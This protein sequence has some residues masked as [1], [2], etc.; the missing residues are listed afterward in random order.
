MDSTNSNIAFL[1]IVHAKDYIAID[2]IKKKNKFTYPKI[3]DYKNK[4]GKLNTIPKDPR[5]Q[6]FLLNP[7]Y[8]I[9]LIGNPIDNKY[10]WDLY[11]QTIIDK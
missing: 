1:F 2:L 7:K 6:T 5:F 4:V 11:K 8:E 3:N 9:I 10:L